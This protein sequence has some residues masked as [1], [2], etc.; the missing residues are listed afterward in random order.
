MCFLHL[1]WYFSFVNIKK[2]FDLELGR[3]PS[4][5]S[6]EE[7]VEEEEEQTNKDKERAQ[8]EGDIDKVEVLP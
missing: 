7:E 2:Y 6:T 1:L 8:V 3:S 4:I 5:L